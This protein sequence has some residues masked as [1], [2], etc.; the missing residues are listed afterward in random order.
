M[1]AVKARDYAP[2][3]LLMGE[4][5]YFIDAISTHIE[6]HA[7]E[8]DDRYFNQDVVFGSDATASQVA[9]MAQGY[10]LMPAQR[11]V[12][13]V[14]EAQVWRS[15]E[16]IERYLER[17]VRS[18]VLVICHKNGTIDRRKKIVTR[19]EAVGVVFESKKKR[20]HELPAFVESYLHERGATV[21]AKAA[22][23][24]AD[25][26]GADLNRLASELDKLLLALDGGE[27][28]VTPQLVEQQI[29]I[30]R[31]YN[32]FEL[33]Q[34]VIERDIVKANRIVNYFEKNPK[35]G[36]LYS[37]LPM[38]FTFFQNLLIAHYTPDRN[39]ERALMAALELKSVWATRDYFAGMRNYS[40]MKTYQILFKIRETD[41]RSKGIDNP[42]TGGG[43][44]MKELIFYIMH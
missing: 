30:S 40:A 34:A 19:A 6:H 22:A 23:M 7:L 33:R 13:I 17:P 2:V 26:I 31:E 28:T 25:N 37:F 3:Y 44:L 43:D 27:R 15:Y 20:E 18:T 16:A 32:A 41:A 39:N 24:V 29:G 38:L 21:D 35:A 42:A 14:K 9:A 11:R 12:V 5:S 36:S 1:R 10:P 8:P 4:E